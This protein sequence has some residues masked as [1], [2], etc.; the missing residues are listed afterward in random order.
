LKVCVS[1]AL[2]LSFAPIVVTRPSQ[3]KSP[4]IPPK[5]LFLKT[6]SLK[7][8]SQPLSFADMSV[9]VVATP[10]GAVCALAVVALRLGLRARHHHGRNDDAPSTPEQTACSGPPPLVR[11]LLTPARRHR[12]KVQ[13]KVRAPYWDRSVRP[14]TPSEEGTARPLLR[15][16][17]FQ[18]K[19]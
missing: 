17:P 19:V 1:R 9:L 2:R 4:S 13:F 3:N 5:L 8:Q 14:A 7:K 11:V 6:Q 16:S 10:A 12:V 18:P 15:V